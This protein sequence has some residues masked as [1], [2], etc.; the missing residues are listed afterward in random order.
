MQTQ[1]SLGRQDTGFSYDVFYW[2][3]AVIPTTVK[4]SSKISLPNGTGHI[5]AGDLS[6]LSFN[7]IATHHFPYRHVPPLEMTQ[8]RAACSHSER[9]RITPVLPSPLSFRPQR[10]EVDKSPHL[11]YLPPLI[12]LAPCAKNLHDIQNKLPGRKLF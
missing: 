7:R 9:K 4:R 10:S 5:M 8:Q 11:W 3:F 6:T 2:H 1:S 12:Q